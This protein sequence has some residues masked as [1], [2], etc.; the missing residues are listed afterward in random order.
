MKLF[1]ITNSSFLRDYKPNDL[2]EEQQHILTLISSVNL[3]FLTG[4]LICMVYVFFRYIHGLH[5]KNKMVRLFYFLA[6]CMTIMYMIFQ[7]N[8]LIIGPDGSY[9][10]P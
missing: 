1:D 10:E 5:I 7:I 8:M 2:T 6:F 4:N 3:L 9:K